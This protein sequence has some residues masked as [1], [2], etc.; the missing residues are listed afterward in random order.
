MIRP[1][2]IARFAIAVTA[3]FAATNLGAQTFTAQKMSIGGDGF[4]DYLSV[5]TATNR[6]FVSR[7]THIM[8]VAG[9]AGQVVGDIL[10]TPRV[11]GAALVPSENRGFTTNG[12][13]SSVTM[14]DL[15]T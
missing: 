4:F 13:D 11:H 15:K 6:V 8:A 1:A 12:G 10:N 3:L 9:G 14:F 5:D 7:G 2:T